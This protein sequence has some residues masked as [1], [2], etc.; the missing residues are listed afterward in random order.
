MECL[1]PRENESI[2]TVRKANTQET[3][4]I[5][6]RESVMYNQPPFSKTNVGKVRWRLFCNNRRNRAIHKTIKTEGKCKVCKRI[7]SCAIVDDYV[8]R[9]EDADIAK[10][11]LIYQC[12]FVNCYTWVYMCCDSSNDMDHMREL[13]SYICDINERVGGF[14]SLGCREI[15]KQRFS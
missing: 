4:Q 13:A 7:L 15:Y 9:T 8:R 2:V 6:L 5:R 1:S 3:F 11:D 10:D 12:E 14:C